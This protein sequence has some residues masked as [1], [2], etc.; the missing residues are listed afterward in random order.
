V[1]V[2][3]AP[4]LLET[5]TDRLCDVLVYVDAPRSHRLERVRRTRGWT[6]GELARRESAQWP[7]E[8]KKRRAD[9]VIRN[10][11]SVARTRRQVREVWKKI[12]AG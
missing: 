1:V 4:L 3:D 5:G 7:L 11:G 8:K 6:A 12:V 10:T 9:Y 2:I